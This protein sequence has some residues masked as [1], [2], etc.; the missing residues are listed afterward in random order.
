MDGSEVR[1]FHSAVATIKFS[2]GADSDTSDTESGPE[3]GPEDSVLPQQNGT[4]ERTHLQNNVD[5]INST[6]NNVKIHQ[7]SKIMQQK[8]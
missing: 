6:N 2:G 7:M 4:A 5:N 1:T 8:L 3:S